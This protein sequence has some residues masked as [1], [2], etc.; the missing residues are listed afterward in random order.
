[1]CGMMKQPPLDSLK[2]KADSRYT[3]VVMAARRA[4]QL[5]DGTAQASVE[6]DSEKPVTIALQ[7]IYQS[8]V[9]YER[10]S[11]AK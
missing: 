4:R 7:E 10:P 9:S 1:M 6:I 8:T 5:L 2:E 3:L 11:A